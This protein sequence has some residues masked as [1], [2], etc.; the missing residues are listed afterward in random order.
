M[1]V[2]IT[3]VAG[4]IGYYVAKQL[5][6]EGHSVFGIDNLNDYYDQQLKD[7]RL[8]WLRMEPNNDKQF[9]FRYADLRNY[10]K[11]EQYLTE[12][13]PDVILHLAAQ[14]GVRH[15]LDHPEE[16]IE[17]N[18]VGT[19]NLFEAAKKTGH[20]N[21][22][23]ASSS[24]VYGDSQDTDHPVSLYAATKKTTELLAHSYHKTNGMNMLGLRFFTVYGPLGRPDMAY[25]T[26]TKKILAGQTIDVYN[27]GNLSRDFTYVT[28]IADGVVGAIKD[29][30]TSLPD[31]RVCD[32]GGGHPYTLME[33]ITT[34][35]KTMN[36]EAI[37]NYVPMQTGDVKETLSDNTKAREWFGYNP[38][39]TLEQ[40]IREFYSWYMEYYH[41]E[42]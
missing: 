28:D 30:Y 26:F 10:K 29:V 24:S 40:G 35:E 1:K 38:K 36:K 27:H 17:S 7:E 41:P 18:V 6:K 3:G 20:K 42:V 22:V 15:S 9:Q 5:I 32:L 19:F 16:Y 13:Q 39:T 2:F 12:Y 21:I 23:Y 14:A 11:L 31:C 33:F 8:F 34:I 25:F 4:F 37:K